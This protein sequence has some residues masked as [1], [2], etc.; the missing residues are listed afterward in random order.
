[1]ELAW[2]QKQTVRQVRLYLSH[3][4]DMQIPTMLMTYPFRAIPT[5][6][7][8]FSVYARVGGKM[9][10]VGAVRG[11]YRRQAVVDLEEPVLTDRLRLVV[12]ATHG[13]PR[14]EVFEVRVY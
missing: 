13:S 10:R 6:L 14:A 3:D 11:H 9:K 7:K 5:V 2:P 1:M 8:D 4:P 12:E